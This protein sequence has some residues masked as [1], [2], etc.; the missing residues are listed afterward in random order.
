M[1]F[2]RKMFDKGKFFCELFFLNIVDVCMDLRDFL[3]LYVMDDGN[4]DDMIKSYVCILIL[5][6][7]RI[8]KC[9]S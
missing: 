2:E 4:F 3:V 5:Y 1:L 7:R 8:F 9:L 6:S